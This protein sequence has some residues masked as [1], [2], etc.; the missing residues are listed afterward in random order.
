M[1]LVANVKLM[2]LMA[3]T[4]IMYNFVPFPCLLYKSVY[5]FV[6]GGTK[7]LFPIA[8]QMWVEQRNIISGSSK[9][10][11]RNSGKVQ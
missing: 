9:K 2:T 7:S 5:F 6:R 4:F 11:S 8:T 3:L 1:Q 10:Y